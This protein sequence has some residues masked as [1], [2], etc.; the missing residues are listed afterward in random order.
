MSV[1]AALLVHGAG[2]GGWEWCLWR[3]AFEGAGI[4]A[5]APDLHAAASGLVA[6]TL[7]AY[8]DQAGAELAALPRPRVAVGASL[9]GLLA[10]LAAADAGA[11]ALV[12][13][14][15]LPPAPLHRRLPARAWPDRVPWGTDARLAGTRRALPDADPATALHAFRRWRDESGQVLREAA[16]GIAMDG[17]LPARILCIA[18]GRDADVPPA[19]TTALAARLRATLLHLPGASHA[20]PL[21]GAGAPAL[22][23]GVVRWLR[24]G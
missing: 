22:A 24:E 2:A 18:S 13:V 12:L 16:A 20:G 17:P 4:A 21:L 11:D 23:A 1:R 19:L 7:Q 3:P 8:R 15:P 14:N 5:H 10:L 9:G 6:T